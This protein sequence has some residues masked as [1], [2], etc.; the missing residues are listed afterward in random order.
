MMKKILYVG[1]SISAQFER[2][3]KYDQVVNLGVGGFKL[4]SMT[5]YAIKEH[6]SMDIPSLFIK[7]MM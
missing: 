2:L 6:G 5:F 7:H 3:K 1:D 4:V